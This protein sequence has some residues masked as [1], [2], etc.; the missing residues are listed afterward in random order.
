MKVLCYVW[1]E[2][3][4]SA[5]KLTRKRKVG[6]TLITETTFRDR[7]RWSGSIRRVKEETLIRNVFHWIVQGRRKINKK[8]RRR[9]R[10][11]KN[12]QNWET[13]L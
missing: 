3:W 13:Y 11:K 7:L 12:I 2:V 6:V 8:R 4:P 1:G 10:R 9:R 5:E